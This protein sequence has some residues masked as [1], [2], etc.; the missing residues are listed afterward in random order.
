[1]SPLFQY[2]EWQQN[3]KNFKYRWYSEAESSPPSEL[4]LIDDTITAKQALENAR[5]GIGMLWVGDY[6]N[7]RNLLQALARRIDK[8]PR[9][10][11]L[12]KELEPSLRF[13][14]HRQKQ[15]TRAE[16]LG[17]ILIA[18]NEN[19]VI[20]LRR[21]QEVFL[22][23]RE[24]LG[25]ITE[26]IVMP[27][28]QL[29]AI[30]SAHEWRKKG[31]FLPS[32]QGKI[33]PHFGVFS[34][35]RGEYLELVST[36]KLPQECNLAFDIGTG[37][38]VLSIALA[39]R[40]VPKIVATD[41]DQR[42]IACAQ[43]NITKLGMQDKIE[44]IQSSL[45]PQGKANL[46]ICNPPWLPGQPSSSIENAIFDVDSKFLKDFLLHSREH[47]HE[48]GQVWLILSDL[49][50]HL[51][52]RTSEDLALWIAKGGLS[53]FTRIDIKA[54]HPKTKNADDPLHF[55]RVKETTSLWI[56]EVERQSI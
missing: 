33:T 27:L 47:L 31:V 40:G 36:A 54:R 21:G 29:L 24:V 51:G 30:V 16:L 26:G 39:K 23:C 2:V 49:A 15:K 46:I 18:L 14:N 38:G 44:L 22:A 9:V 6:Q 32:I 11:A 41:I 4:L 52:L 35:V 28:K 53:V 20:E 45:F 42:A 17:K 50:E 55:A 48:N 43:E 7:G 12:K 25:E 1:M 37:T 10:G 34:P 5:Q 3:D 56:L 13:A 8:P 19:F